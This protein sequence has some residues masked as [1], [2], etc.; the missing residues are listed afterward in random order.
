MNNK[1]QENGRLF[2]FEKVAL[3]YK[4]NIHRTLIKGY[5]DLFN[6]NHFLSKTVQIVQIF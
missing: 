3:L 1:A 6:F 2:C 5:N 4:K